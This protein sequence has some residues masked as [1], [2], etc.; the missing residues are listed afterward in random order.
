MG[1]SGLAGLLFVALVIRDRRFWWGIIPGLVLLAVAALV[2]LDYLA[3]S[4]T[5]HWGG[6]RHR[7][8]NHA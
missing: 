8:S 7:G 3:P 2:A 6:Y 1:H 4:V 5:T